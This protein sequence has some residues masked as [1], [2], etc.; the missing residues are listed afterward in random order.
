MIVMDV[1]AGGRTPAHLTSAEFTAAA[2][3]ALAP[4]GWYAANVSD[5]PPLAHA[6]GRV[7][8]VRSVFRHACVIAE[9][10]VLRGRSFGNLVVAAADHELPVPELSSR[11]AADPVPAR[12]LAGTALARFAGRSV[13]IT[14]ASAEPSPAPP[15]EALA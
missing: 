13:P 12:L 6:R 8:A 15:P 14:D 10:T 3:R 1:F 2:A 9:D 11:T 4:S 7:A 5:G